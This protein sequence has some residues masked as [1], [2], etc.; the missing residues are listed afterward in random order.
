MLRN[1][2][3]SYGSI[4]IFM[5]WLMAI[6]I[7]GMFALGLWMV[8]LNYYDSWYHDAPYIHKAVG[9]LLLFALIFRFGWR[10]TNTRPDLMGEVWEKFIA[11]LVHRMHY[12]LLFTITITGYLI[13]TAEGVGIDIFGLFTVPASLSFNKD[14]A[15]LIGLIHLYVACAAIGLAA[16]HAAAA[17]KHHFIDK[18][19]T[20]LRMLGKTKNKLHN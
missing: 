6:V 18:D 10:L 1:T 19:T 9:M 4:A 2:S 5:H 15:D 3:T 17:L 12:L 16:A 11:L 20:L 7:F 14:E 13:P 8:E